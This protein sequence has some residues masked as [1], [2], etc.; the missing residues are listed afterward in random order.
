M[1]LR[2]RSGTLE[3]SSGRWD[4]RFGVI[5]M[6]TQWE[7]ERYFAQIVCVTAAACTAFKVHDRRSC[8]YIW[9]GFSVF[10]LKSQ[11]AC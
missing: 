6:E 3:L 8:F 7:I 2:E 1:F 5:T 4:A 10:D 9:L 11:E